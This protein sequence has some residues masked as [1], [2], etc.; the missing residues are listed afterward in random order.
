MDDHSNKQVLEVK[1]GTA[2][3]GLEKLMAAR[4]RV[5]A[6]MRGLPNGA[7]KWSLRKRIDRLD[8]RI[9]E[10]KRPGLR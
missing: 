9:A 6:E 7:T 10:L 3:T 1:A 4:G 8:K 2:N 5:V